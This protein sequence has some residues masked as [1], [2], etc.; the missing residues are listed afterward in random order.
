MLEAHTVT[1]TLGNRPI[2]HGVSLAARPG[3]VTAI[4][5]PNG[6]GKTTLMRAL[7]GELRF[8]G[9]VSLDGDDITALPPW[10]LALRRAVLPQAT[11]LAFPFTLR[12]VVAMGLAAGTAAGRPAV[13]EDAL[14]AVDLA[15]RAGARFQTLSGGEQARGHLARALAQVWDDTPAPAPR[16]L[17][18]DEPV[19]SLD[20]GHQML[21]MRR[22]AAFA[23][24]GGGV[25]A[26]MHDLN[27]TAMFADQ[28]LL[29]DAG[30]ITAAGAPRDVLTDTRLS[31]AYRTPLRVN[32]TPPDGQV[33]LLPQ[34]IGEG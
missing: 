31:T 8:T 11:A 17:M 23:A 33:F 25:V 30:R 18:L 2:L 12:E 7:T 32:R 6:S 22:V 4:V 5:G 27:L 13:V 24:G 29:V 14:A 10:R 26:V 16:W 3:A 28:V 34:A 15:D 20:I 21:V 19:A 9:K 1:V